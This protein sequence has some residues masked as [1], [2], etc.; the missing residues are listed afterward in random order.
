M[1]LF[2]DAVVK[3]NRRGRLGVPG[4]G[5][6]RGVAPGVTN[7]HFSILASRKVN[8]DFRPFQMSLCSIVYRF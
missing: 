6:S 7:L 5:N 2:S 8:A 4:N 1:I 3:F